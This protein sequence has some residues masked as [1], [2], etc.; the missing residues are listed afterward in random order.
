MIKAVLFDMD[1][2]TIDSER[3]YKDALLEKG[4]MMDLPFPPEAETGNVTG[5]VEKDAAAY[6]FDKYGVDCLEWLSYRWIYSD[7][8]F[9]EHGLPLK[10]G[11]PEVFD[12]L[13]ALGCKVALVTSTI[14]VNADRIFS[15][16]DIFTQFDLIVTGDRV[17]NGKPAPDIFLLAAEALGL[18]PSECAVAEDSKNGILSAHAAGML[19][20]FIPD[21]VSPPDHVKP[22][23]WKTIPT[24][25]HL[26]GLV[27]EYNKEHT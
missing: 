21:L 24:L 10:P 25:E 3:V 8:Y 22:L 2:T 14:R 6:L 11:V 9:T 1:G 16:S 15:K 17:K 26:S 13:H 18:R 27:E 7:R 19:P 23:I 4:A 12:R 5:M 20:V